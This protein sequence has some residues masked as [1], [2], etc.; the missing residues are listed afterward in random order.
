MSFEIVALPKEK[1]KGAVIP[2]VT[3]SD[4]YYDFEL[5]PLDQDGCRISIC[6]KSGRKGDRTYT[7][8]M[9][10]QAAGH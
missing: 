2:M 3:R 6:Q 9:V 5:S 10:Q 1:W 4:S 7:G 8:G